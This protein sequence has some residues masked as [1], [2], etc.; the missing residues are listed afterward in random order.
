MANILLIDDDKSIL[1]ALIMLLDAEGH[2][3][4]M[5]AD[6][7]SGLR[8]FADEEFDL[9]LLDMNYSSDTTSGEEG[10]QLI[11]RLRDASALVAIVV[12]TGWATI[13]IAVKAMQQGGN[14]FIEKPW[15]N[16]RLMA[17]IQ[18]QLAL[19]NEKQKTVRLSA[20]NS[21]LRAELDHGETQLVAES[22]I[23]R[24]LLATVEQVAGS[25]INVLI[26]GENGTGK[27]MLARHIH[28]LSRRQQAPFIAVNM[29][30]IS[31]SLFESEMF[32]HVKGA[33]TDARADRVG[34]FELA[35]GGSLFLDEIG[36]IPLSQQAKL[37]RVVEEC[38][39]ER[40]GS[41]KTHSVD[42]RL[43][44]ATNANLSELVDSGGFRQDLLY[45]LNSI[46]LCIPPLRQRGEDIEALARGFVTAH[47]GKYGRSAPG[48]QEEAL[49]ELK[50]YHWP[51]NVRELQ[52]VIERAMVLC[53]E[54]DIGVDHL[55]LPRR[56]AA[57]P[58]VAQDAVVEREGETLE[59]IEKRV[60]EA[61]IRDCG[62]N[63]LAAAR[64]LGLS[65]SAFY[66]R[67]D[68]YGI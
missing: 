21:L 56:S 31:E 49:L 51:G 68:K 26:T 11:G 43:V 60:I 4:R 57:L 36:N 17:I 48:L 42:V 63:M 41:S 23:M 22:A 8:L 1:A 29:G 53:P 40:V 38:Q 16:D 67:I 20:E 27:S 64:S 61:R 25:D 19:R 10:L 46:E 50:N 9:V 18:T 24:T 54:G 28:Q 55:M 52:H 30:A 12:M 45:R 2:K 14:D 62:G 59:S 47:A 35:D 6:P 13:E 7:E 32:G 66:R 39:Y 33:F 58:A 37:L 65:R 15:D 34:R 5:A 44:S 3:V